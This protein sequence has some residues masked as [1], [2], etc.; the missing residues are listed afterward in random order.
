MNTAEQVL[1]DFNALLSRVDNNF[2]ELDKI[3]ESMDSHAGDQLKVLLLE[4][5]A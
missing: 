4:S 5:Q 3:A 1:A 2:E